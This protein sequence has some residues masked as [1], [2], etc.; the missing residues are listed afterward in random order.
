MAA[1]TKA[2]SDAQVRQARPREKEYNLADGGGLFLR[3]KPTGTRTWLFNYFKP[4][5]RTRSNLAIGQYPGVTLSAARQK[6]TEYLELLAQDID[7][8]THRDT[9]ER[10]QQ[11]SHNQTLAVV[12]D[13]WTTIKRTKV[14]KDYAD[15][16]R[17][18]LDLHI[19][20]KLGKLPVHLIRAQ[21]AITVLEPIAARGSLETVKRLC[22]RLNEIMTYC[23]NT[24]LIEHNPLA[25]IGQ[26]FIAPAKNH[27]PTL[28]P[29]QLP[30]LMLKLSRASIR[31]TTRCLI[32]WQL[33][34]MVRPTEAA[35]TRWEEIDL[36]KALWTIPAHRMKK[37]LAHT[38]PLT[39][40]A[41]GLLQTMMPI[42]RHLVHVFPA[43][44][45]SGTHTHQQTANMA[46]K[47]MGYEGQL[48]A[49]GLRALASTTLNEQGFDPDIIESA[50]A[51]IDKNSV[52]AAY[53]RSDYVARRRVMMNWW[54]EHIEAAAHGSLSISG[55]KHL[56]PVLAKTA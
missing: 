49:H 50:L 15:D 42:S 23:V 5:T 46:L 35:G 3:I 21:D 56:R 39:Q 8:K 36:E 2:L 13:A 1:R 4:Y 32:E 12:T 9:A 18:S 28:R 26:A 7:P 41:I 40:Q 24:G 55:H 11:E 19:L 10:L 38:V 22:Q 17:R 27:M 43:D 48:V 52:R 29:D 45:N 30:D 53:N 6:R 20:P 31:I 44:R 37:K 33:H 54:S 14:T 47:R 16:I 25:G 34:T 51:H